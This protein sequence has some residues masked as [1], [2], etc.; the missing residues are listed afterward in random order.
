MSHSQFLG[1]CE[2]VRFSDDCPQGNAELTE[3]AVAQYAARMRAEGLR[4]TG[5]L[6]PTLHDRITEV[7]KDLRLDEVPEVFVVSDPS[8]RACAP[9]ISRNQRPL[10]VLTSG[11]VE[12]LDS[13]EIRFV[14]GH[15]LGHFGLAHTPAT[16]RTEAASEYGRVAES[17]VHRASEISA[18]RVGLIAV[19]S[20]VTCGVVMVKLISGLSS[21]HIQ[22]DVGGFLR[23]LEQTEAETDRV[24]EAFTSHPSLPLRLRALIWFAETSVYSSLVEAGTAG[25]S[26]TE[27]DS[28][29]SSALDALGGGLLPELE[30]QHVDLCAAWLA[31]S[32]AFQDDIITDQ[33]ETVLEALVGTELAGKVLRFGKEFG[34]ESVR[35]KL[36]E[37]LTDHLIRRPRIQERLANVFKAFA[38]S[39][40]V[41]PEGTIAWQELPESL[42]DRIRVRR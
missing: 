11:I 18:D 35:Q 28:D 12:L 27:V 33:E 6:T 32:L 7:A 1:I 36:A 26:L 21:R 13:Q 15:E 4:V 5:A 39:L 16:A 24:W 23:Q 25:R 8:P 9:C 34:F 19:R 17:Y 42:R 29:V 2:S 22:L 40:G 30:Q 41:R 31:G 20:L 10:I 14:I 38:D 37:T 3:H